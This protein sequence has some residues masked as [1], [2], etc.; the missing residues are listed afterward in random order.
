MPLGCRKPQPASM[1]PALAIL[2]RHSPSVTV[3][4]MEDTKG[5]LFSNA[6]ESDAPGGMT[7]LTTRAAA[8]AGGP[9]QPGEFGWSRRNVVRCSKREQSHGSRSSTAR[10]C[11]PVAVSSVV[12]AASRSWIAS[13][14]TSA[15][16][17]AAA[18]HRGCLSEVSCCYNK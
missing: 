13:S 7:V 17:F 10:D 5:A 16:A 14:D 1:L 18:I 3:I 9:R 6:V 4:S 8:R 2:T 12:A 15:V 11:H